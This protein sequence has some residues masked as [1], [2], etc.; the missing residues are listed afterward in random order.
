[1]CFMENVLGVWVRPILC[2]GGWETT[3]NYYTTFLPYLEVATFTILVL[4]LVALVSIASI[5]LGL[6]KNSGAHYLSGILLTGMLALISPFMNY[7][8]APNKIIMLDFRV[9]L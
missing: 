7:N 2:Y 5:L 1:M 6:W 4:I 3:C 8:F 9:C